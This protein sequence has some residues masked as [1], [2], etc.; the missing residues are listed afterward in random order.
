MALEIINAYDTHE[1]LRTLVKIDYVFA[2]PDLDETTGEPINF[3]LTKGGLKALGIARKIPLKDR[4][5]GR[6]D[7]EISLDG[8]WWQHTDE[9]EQRALL[10]H[11][12][13]HIFAT[14]KRDDLGRPIIKL[15]KHDV[16][17]GWF[18][19]VAARHGEFSQERIQAASMMEI[20][21]QFYWPA[22][23]GMLNTTK[24]RALNSRTQKLELTEA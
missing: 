18:N 7:A 12:L 14:A 6:G 22:V 4:A 8:Y 19:C 15:R 24:S 17:F 9:E 2:F 1:S 5:M 10:D 20:Q 16:E 23:A 13:T 21:G 3:A 11:E